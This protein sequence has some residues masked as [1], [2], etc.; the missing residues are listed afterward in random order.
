MISAPDTSPTT[1]RRAAFS[2]TICL[3]LVWIVVAG[4]ALT[5]LIVGVPS[6]M[7]AGWLSLRLL[8]PGALRPRPLGLL[9]LAARF[10]LQALTAGVDVAVRAFRPSLPLNLGTVAYSARMTD[11]TARQAFFTLMSLFPGTLP[12]GD[13]PSGA[14]SIHC[15]DSA[16]PVAA[17]MVTEEA[18]F[19]RAFVRDSQNG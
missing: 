5:D 8:P 14:Q 16:Q 13:A 9:L 1:A 10:P 19:S 15:L 4:H 17:A 18:A 3:F 6:A 12:S 2:R 7:L 11:E